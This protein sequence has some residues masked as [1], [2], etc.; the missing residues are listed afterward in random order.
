MAF[1]PF[2]IADINDPEQIRVVFYANGRMGH[3]PLNAL[4]N[5]M[6]KRVERTDKKTNKNYVKM[7]QR[8][9]A[10]E[11]CVT[12]IMESKKYDDEKAKGDGKSDDPS[13]TL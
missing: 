13:P 2:S 10:L 7:E 5:Q 3:A 8:I 1:F 9:S 6:H 4:L 12:T 11:D